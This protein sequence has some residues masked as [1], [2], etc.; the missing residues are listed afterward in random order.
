[1]CRATQ[2][3]PTTHSSHRHSAEMFQRIIAQSPFRVLT[4]LSCV[5]NLRTK[6]KRFLKTSSADLDYRSTGRCCTPPLVTTHDV[7]A[8][9]HSSAT[10]RA[11]RHTHKKRQHCGTSTLAPQLPKP[12]LKTANDLARITPLTLRAP[13]VQEMSLLP[14][15]AQN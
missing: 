8:R 5:S 1:M 4:S 3:L 10:C 9:L 13:M 12:N 2:T 7:R 15:L 6:T 11:A 14:P